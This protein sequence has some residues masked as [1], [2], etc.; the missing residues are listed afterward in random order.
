L[1]KITKLKG[2]LFHFGECTKIEH[3]E[4][5][6]PVSESKEKMIDVLRDSKIHVSIL[7]RISAVVRVQF[8]GTYVGQEVLL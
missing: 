8:G 7:L 5:R 4:E 2:N 6:V 3:S 1:T